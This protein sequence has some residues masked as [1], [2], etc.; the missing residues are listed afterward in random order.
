MCAAARRD[1]ID[2]L[3]K[4]RERKGEIDKKP[5]EHQRQPL[6]RA[7][8]GRRARCRR[9]DERAST[10]RTSWTCAGCHGERRHRLEDYAESSNCRHIR[11]S[12]SS[13]SYQSGRDEPDPKRQVAGVDTNMSDQMRRCIHR[14]YGRTPS[15]C[16][17]RRRVRT[18]SEGSRSSTR[19]SSRDRWRWTNVQIYG[20][21]LLLDNNSKDEDSEASTNA[22]AQFPKRSEINID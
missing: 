14:K 15:Q 2:R 6:S 1:L 13:S 8:G 4:S 11:E 10:H 9:R 16:P 3:N 17:P 12:T 20:E 21:N 22:N 5:A 18:A 19:S 7:G